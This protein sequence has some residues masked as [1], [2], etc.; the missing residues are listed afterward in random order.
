MIMKV[1][2]FMRLYYTK[3]I[4]RNFNLTYNSQSTHTVQKYIV[5][6]SNQIYKQTVNHQSL[7]LDILLR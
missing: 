2:V 1:L 5:L 6:L 3:Q 7:M 4:N